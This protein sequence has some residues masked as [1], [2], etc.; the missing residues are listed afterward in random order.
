MLEHACM[1]KNIA[2]VRATRY[3]Q[4]A[5]KRGVRIPD[6]DAGVRRT[7]HLAF[8]GKWRKARRLYAG[9]CL[10]EEEYS[11]GPGNQV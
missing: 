2:M 8:I 5:R 3:E 10:H 9:A 1:R 11:H 7:E 6:A 4:G